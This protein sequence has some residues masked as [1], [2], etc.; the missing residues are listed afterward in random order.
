[1]KHAPRPLW[2][3]LTFDVRQRMKP[4]AICL[5]VFGL[6]GC[7]ANSPTP[8]RAVLV[9]AADAKTAFPPTKERVAAAEAEMKRARLRQLTTLDFL[10][11]REDD[12]MAE[13]PVTE[14]TLEPDGRKSFTEG[15]IRFPG[16]SGGYVI[17]RYH[18]LTFSEG[19]VVKHE[20]EDR[21]TACVILS[22]VR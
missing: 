5:F 7:A 21:I 14:L 3:W 4:A 8:P 22:P 15:V 19:K 20:I 12:V 6:T 16:G 10:G 17:S 11:L 2:P 18:I 9:S 1:V 13:L